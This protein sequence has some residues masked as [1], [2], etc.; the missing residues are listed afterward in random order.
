MQSACLGMGKT[1]PAFCQ[2]RSSSSLP[3]LRASL[4]LRIWN[5][6]GLHSLA[7]KC[8]EST[9]KKISKLLRKLISSKSKLRNFPLNQEM[10]NL[11]ILEFWCSIFHGRHQPKKLFFTHLRGK[12]VT[13]CSV[14]TGKR[15][16][17]R[18]I[19]KS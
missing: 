11:C 9:Y 15:I 19:W 12:K 7:Q 16:K 5:F 1:D 4:P 13:K 3:P 8:K 6:C 14:I 2:P 17:L 10:E 18:Q